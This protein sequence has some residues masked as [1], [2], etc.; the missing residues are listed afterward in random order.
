[1]DVHQ[2][3]SHYDLDVN[4]AL[5]NESNVILRHF[6]PFEIPLRGTNGMNN[7]RGAAWLIPS[8]CTVEMIQNMC[9]VETK[10]QSAPMLCMADLYEFISDNDDSS[11]SEMN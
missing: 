5:F 8:D 10:L 9:C 11:L 1:M 3:A 7:I 4:V 2:L 6:G